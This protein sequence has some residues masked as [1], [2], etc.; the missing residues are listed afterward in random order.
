MASTLTERYI[1][2][3]VRSLPVDAQEDV[4]AELSASI[5]DDI[6]ARLE[7][8]ESPAEA[9][10]AVISEL[11]DPDR[12]AAGYVDRPL[13][14]IGPKYY[15]TWWRLLKLL[16]MIVPAVAVTGVTVANLIADAPV[17]EIIG[18]VISTG[19]GA[20][21]HVGFWTTVV[22]AI[23]ER[24]GADTGTTWTP[25]QLPEPQ[26]TGVGRGDLIGSLVFLAL[27]IA[28]LLWDRFVGFAFFRDGAIDV[29]VGL[30]EQTRAVPVLNSELW[31]W[32]IGGLFVLIAAEAALAIA[33]YRNRG[34]TSGFAVFN[35]L[36]AVAFTVG[37]LYLLQARELLNPEFLDLT[38]GRD[39]V[40]GDVGRTLAIIT[41]VSIVGV[42]GWDSIDGWRKARKNRHA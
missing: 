6:E 11:G 13:Q 2:A 23:L 4:R 37:A 12:L 36:L 35:T 29:G 42:S 18:S 1:A 21:V 38:L 30:G 17:G 20:V 9:E 40:P 16:W 14:L 3:T 25:D 19:I 31:P 5:A 34:W 39:D 24:T 41:A 26:P 32:W 33:V 10:H 7:Q 28:A 8:G 15:L 27:A 22:F